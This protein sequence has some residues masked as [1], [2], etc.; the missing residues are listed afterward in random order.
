MSYRCPS[1][2]RIIF[3][4]RLK[5]CDFCAAEIP[6]S[7]RFTPEE[8]AALDREMAELAS[9]RKQRDQEADKAEKE[10]RADDDD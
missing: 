1:C 2:Q 4:R 5:N 7:L 6:D 10:R 8:I 9:R 3:N